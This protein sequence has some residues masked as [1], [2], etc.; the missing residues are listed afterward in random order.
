M[1][2]PRS[3]PSARG[4][5]V[6]LST[7][8]IF[9]MTDYN[10]QS[11]CILAPLLIDFGF[12]AIAVHK[13]PAQF[14]GFGVSLAHMYTGIVVIALGLQQPIFALLRPH[15][16]DAGEEPSALRAVWE[17]AHKYLGWLALLGGV[18]NCALGAAVAAAKYE[19]GLSIGAAVVL[20]VGTAPVVCFGFY[21]CVR[22]GGVPVE[23]KV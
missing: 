15:K 11:S 16:P 22:G 20:G 13:G 12:V 6:L 23:A 5:A 2:S 10:V 14:V 19:S 1:A 7:A 21:R 9:P 17:V 4:C 3:S 8:A 18:T